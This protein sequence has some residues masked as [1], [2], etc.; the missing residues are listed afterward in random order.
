MND[1][2][3]SKEAL[4]RLV[5]QQL[6]ES[7]PAIT[8]QL[9]QP[10]QPEGP[11]WTPRK[12]PKWATITNVLAPLTDGA[13][14]MWAMNQSG[15]N[16]QV[17]EGNTIFGKNP[18]AGKIMGIKASQAAIQG[19]LTHVARKTHPNSARAIGIGSAIVGGIP[20]AMNIRTGL[21]AK[22]ANKGSK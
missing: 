19:I 21:K 2:P 20:T 7:P 8:Q 14:T 15:P 1:S 12:G 13:S 16:A 9:D 3:F 17:N 18:S 10:Y 11:P 6:A 22:E 4:N 5:A